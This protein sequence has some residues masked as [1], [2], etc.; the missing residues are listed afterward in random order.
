MT[1]TAE[2]TSY[3]PCAGDIVHFPD[4]PLVPN[5]SRTYEI[6]AFDGTT[7]SFRAG[8][9]VYAK[10]WAALKALGMERVTMSSLPSPAAPVPTPLTDAHGTVSAAA[11]SLVALAAAPFSDQ[12]DLREHAAII[13]QLWTAADWA[14]V[15]FA[16]QAGAIGITLSLTLDTADTVSDPLHLRAAQSRLNAANQNCASAR[17]ALDAVR[18]ELRRFGG[19]GAA[20]GTR[21]WRLADAASGGLCATA[22]SLAGHAGPPRHTIYTTA[23]LPVHL[24]I[25]GRLALC[26]TKMA[27]IAARAHLHIVAAISEIRRDPGTSRACSAVARLIDQAGCRLLDAAKCAGQAVA[28]LPAADDV[29]AGARQ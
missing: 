28:A 5:R 17:D 1:G 18:G 15:I 9:H 26:T 27:L 7:V 23:S 21:A 8:S 2:D 4:A 6:T 3:I 10:S 14:A 24:D 20:G 29:P 19:T 16:R 22:R 13:T 25:T 11:S 12:A